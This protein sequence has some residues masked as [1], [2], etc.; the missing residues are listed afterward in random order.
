MYDRE[1]LAAVQCGKAPPFRPDEI[2]CGY[3]A[4]ALRKGFA[5]P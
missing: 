4:A 2:F 5:F 1:R 3:A